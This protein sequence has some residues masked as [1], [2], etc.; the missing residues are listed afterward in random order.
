MADRGQTLHD[1]VAG[2]SVF[3]L[4]VAVVLGLLPSVVAPFQSGGGAADAT[5]ATHVADRIVSSVSVAGT[6]NVLDGEAVSSLMSLDESA[7]RDRFG[8]HSHQYVNLT[9][10]ELNGSAFLTDGAG[11]T[12][13]VQVAGAPALGEDA[14][15]AARVVRIDDPDFDC[16]P[17]CRLV[18]R[19]W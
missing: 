11:A 1:Y 8:L 15:T 5:R 12:G 7:L 10:Q 2:I 3:I 13:A 6:P 4:T 14:V 17:A 9:L 18:V 19:V 16:N